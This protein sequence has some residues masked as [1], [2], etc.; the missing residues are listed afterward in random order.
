[1][2]PRDVSLTS[3]KFAHQRFNAARTCQVPKVDLPPPQAW[4]AA[5][6]QAGPLNLINLTGPPSQT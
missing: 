1:M 3:V 6:H 5:R 4:K 2:G